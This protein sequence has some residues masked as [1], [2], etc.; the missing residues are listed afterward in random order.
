MKK[1][2]LLKAV[3]LFMVLA[4][5]LSFICSCGKSEEVVFEL[6]GQKIE[7]DLYRY[8]LSYFKS[9]FVYNYKDIKDTEECWNSE[10]KD[11]MTNGEYVMQYTE[12]YVKNYLCALKLYNDYGLSLPD[13][14]TEQIES[15]LNEQIEYYGS[16]SALNKELIKTCNITVS[17][18]EEIYKIEAKVAQLQTYLYGE[19]GI[20]TLS[21]Q[22]TDDYYK[23]SYYRVKY[24]YFSISNKYLYDENGKIQ[25]DSE[26]NY[27]T[28]AM[29]ADEIAASK[30][31]A[32]E[33]YQKALAGDDFNTLINDYNDPVLRYTDTYP[34]GFYITSNDINAHGF[35]VVSNAQS[36]EVGDIKLVSDEYAMYVIQ[37][38]PLEDNAY[39]SENDSFQF[40]NLGSLANAYYYQKLLSSMWDK[41]TINQEY[42]DSLSILEVAKNINF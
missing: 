13:T 4:L 3:A 30:A 25:T 22:E 19:N 10:I 40:S 16:R 12:N 26:G 39:Q 27:K 35:T 28:E 18:L 31:K 24:L 8:W 41:I 1:T 14:A 5:A 11:G 37:K 15:D 23:N 42:L 21:A 29:T 6:D 17:R 2:G 7:A 9:Y 20:E 38:L 32:E 36:L 34:N 33:A